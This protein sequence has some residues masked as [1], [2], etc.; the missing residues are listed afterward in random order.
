LGAK[1]TFN[2]VCNNY[3][4]Y[5]KRNFG[6]KC[7]IIFD[8]YRG[9]VTFSPKVAE[10][11][12]RYGFIQNINVLFD[13]KSTVDVKQNEFMSSNENKA[14]LIDALKVKFTEQHYITHQAT[15]DT[16][17]LIVRTAVNLARSHNV[18]V[19][20]ADVDLLALLVSCTLPSSSSEVFFM[21]PSAGKVPPLLFSQSHP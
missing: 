17:V 5:V 20:G 8:D 11:K 4:E 19:V 18:V 1:K 2:V 10:Q 15:D 9:T 3:V 6:E 13:L 7:V 14:Q 16:D 21:K 12:R